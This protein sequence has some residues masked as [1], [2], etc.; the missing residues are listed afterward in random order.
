[1]LVGLTEVVGVTEIGCLVIMPLEMSD[2]SNSVSTPDVV[3]ETATEDTV[4]VTVLV[5]ASDTGGVVVVEITVGVGVTDTRVPEVPDGSDSVGKV[6]TVGVSGTVL[7][8]EVATV[9][10]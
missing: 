7:Y 3:I 5:R 8:T 1:V 9:L 2:E 10:V 6:E 4:L